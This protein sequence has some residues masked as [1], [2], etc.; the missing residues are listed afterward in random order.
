MEFDYKNPKNRR[1]NKVNELVKKYFARK[2]VEEKN[3]PACHEGVDQHSTQ[4]WS[5]LSG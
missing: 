4:D 2:N 1:S 5:S 3:N